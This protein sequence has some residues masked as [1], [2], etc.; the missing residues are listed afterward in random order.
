MAAHRHY[1]KA[2]ITEALIALNVKLP[3]ETPVSALELCGNDEGLR[4]PDKKKFNLAIGRME[5]GEEFST[6]ATTRHTGFVFA[7]ADKKQVFQ[8]R[9][10]GFTFSRLAPYERW[11]TLRDEA[12]RLWGIYRRIAKPVTVE[13]LAVRYINR[14][15]FPLPLLE[16]KDYL[17]TVPEIAPDLP[18]GLAGFFMQLNIP[19][20]D[21]DSTLL[22]NETIIEPPGPD[23]VSIVL[24]IDLFR[25]AQVPSD[26]EEMW[27][28]FEKLHM[29]KNE[30][31]EAC[32]TDRTRELIR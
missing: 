22:L 14:L 8:V 1:S 32:I 23:R 18:Q 19:Q 9:L 12:R 26:E 3:E 11:E 29:R 4:Y 25:A 20:P 7:N 28:F 21:I 24:D 16:M 15:D 10:D 13:R 6:S 31:F 2:P 30:I 27:A 17:R 5:L